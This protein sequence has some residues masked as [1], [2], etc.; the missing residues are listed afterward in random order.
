MRVAGGPAPPLWSAFF[1]GPTAAAALWLLGARRLTS[2]CTTC[3]RHHAVSSAEHQ[4]SKSS[5]HHKE[6]R[7]DAQDYPPTHGAA[8][9][10][11]HN[12]P[13]LSHASHSPARRTPRGHVRS[14]NGVPV[15]AWRNKRRDTESKRSA[16][17]ERKPAGHAERQSAISHSPRELQPAA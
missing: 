3:T 4:Q 15:H 6:N 16:T 1:G 7:S 14:P 10:T 12:R 9:A 5:C 11:Y 2:S 13:R 8:S 17:T